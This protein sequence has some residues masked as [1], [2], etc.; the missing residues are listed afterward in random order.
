[1]TETEIVNWL[2][3]FLVADPEFTIIK[4]DTVERYIYATNN[5][6]HRHD[7][8]YG[9]NTLREAVMAAAGKRLA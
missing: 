6:A 2:E 1:M 7:S 3:Q 4:I 9:G 8:E 5:P